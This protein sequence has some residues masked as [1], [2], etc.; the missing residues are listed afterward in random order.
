MAAAIDSESRDLRRT[1]IVLGILGLV[2]QLIGTALDFNDVIMTL[3]RAQIRED[4]LIWNPVWN[5][6]LQHVL[7][8]FHRPFILWDYGI[9]A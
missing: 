5:P 3:M 2:V 4:E 7:F 6:I 8:L 9:I 1:V